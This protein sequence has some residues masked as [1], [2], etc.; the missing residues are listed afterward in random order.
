MVAIDGTDEAAAGGP[1]CAPAADDG[2]D[3]ASVGGPT[4][5]SAAEPLAHSLVSPPRD[6]PASFKSAV[7]QKYVLEELAGK[8]VRLTKE[9]AEEHVAA[10]AEC[11]VQLV[12]GDSRSNALALRSHLGWQCLGGFA[13]FESAERAGEYTG[14]PYWWNGSAKGL[15]IDLTPRAEQHRAIVLVESAHTAVPDPSAEE[16]R[17]FL[18]LR[19]AEVGEKAAM[20]DY[21]EVKGEAKKSAKDAKAAKQYEA[22]AAKLEHKRLVAALPPSPYQGLLKRLALLPQEFVAADDL[23]MHDM[24]LKRPDMQALAALIAAHGPLNVCNLYMQNNSLGDDGFELLVSCFASMPK[25]NNVY[26]Q[27]NHIGVRGV[28]ALCNRPPAHRLSQLL[29][30]NNE[31]ATEGYE[32]FSQAIGSGRLKV[33]TLVVHTFYTAHMAT[34]EAREELKAAC[35]GVG[36]H[37]SV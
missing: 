13:L 15:W 28:R 1:A 19:A 12:A 24:N 22:K 8:R 37:V 17:R 3:G 36:T 10:A 2:S 14:R 16:T 26:L 6:W 11:G 35:K 20:A 25:L 29:I 18:Q 9:P 5:A 21:R 7:L 23:V 31:F 27:T 34:G 32:L 33:Q 4:S 30:W